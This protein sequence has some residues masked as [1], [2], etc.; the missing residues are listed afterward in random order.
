MLR[1]VKA[2]RFLMNTEANRKRASTHDQEEE[3]T[4]SELATICFKL[5]ACSLSY[6]HVCN[7][8]VMCTV[9][10]GTQPHMHENYDLTKLIAVPLCLLPNSS[11]LSSSFHSGILWHSVMTHGTVKPH[12]NE[13][14]SD[15]KI[16]SLYPKICN[17][18]IFMTL[19]GWQYN[20][21]TSL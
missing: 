14:I 11:Y 12:Y 13:A 16:Y 7:Y 19:Y 15:T 5:K 17:K 20:S 3:R 4:N 10:R 6:E 9:G 21:F 18:R 8:S 2:L 1:P